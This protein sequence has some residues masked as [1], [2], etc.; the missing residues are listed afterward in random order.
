VTRPEVLFHFSEDPSITRFEPHVAATAATDEAL[1]WGIDAG[2]QDLY[3]F[4]RDCPRVTLCALPTTSAAD[5]E[6][7]LGFST[8]H[9]VAAVEAGW[10]DRIRKTRLY[11][12]RLASEDFELREPN[13]G[14]WVS[15]DSVT[16]VSV[17]PVGD[18]LSA[19]ANADV[20]IRIVP[21]LWPLY[22]AVVASS[23]GFSVI[24]W[25]NA[26]PKS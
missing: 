8:A 13:A 19:L 17:E 6:R 23:L 24:R 7:F 10:L 18:L 5:R 21:N 9:R 22:E 26:A 25:R 3:F 4:P 15:R 20:E 2:H 14:Y 1:V 16:P 11:R 12:Y